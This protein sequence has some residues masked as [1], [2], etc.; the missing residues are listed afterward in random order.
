MKKC[1][2]IQCS[3]KKQDTPCQS[4]DMYQGSNFKKIYNL[5]KP[6]EYDIYIISG[7]Y[8]LIKD[9]D[10]IEPY[11]VSLELLPPG[12]VKNYTSEYREEY[13]KQGLLNQQLLK[14]ILTQQMSMLSEYGE[15]FT[16][17]SQEYK[18]IYLECGGNRNKSLFLQDKCGGIFNLCKTLPDKLKQSTTEQ[19]NQFFT[20]NGN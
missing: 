2:I 4:K 5:V 19:T 20:F 6:Y 13:K 17:F 14:P 12:Y 10:I 8:G 7:K 16:I 18:K 15:I 3:H 11:N 1:F 9:T